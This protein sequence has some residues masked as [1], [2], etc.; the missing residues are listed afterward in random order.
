[1]TRGE[2]DY[3]EERRARRA[4]LGLPPPEEW[5]KLPQH[6]FLIVFNTASA[7]DS[8]ADIDDYFAFVEKEKARR[9]YEAVVNAAKKRQAHP[10]F[11][12]AEYSLREECLAINGVKYKGPSP[13]ESANE[14]AMRRAKIRREIKQ[15]KGQFA[16]AEKEKACIKY[17]ALVNAAKKRQAH[18]RFRRAEN[19]LREECLAIDGVKYKGPSPT[20]SANDTTVRRRKIRREIKLKKVKQK[21]QRL[22]EQQT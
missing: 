7:A 9:K 3:E 18:L 6:E 5:S 15:R 19:S 14:T 13:T 21:E 12:R 2:D 22:N 10:I 1:M 20:E 17:E 4:R 16:S 8:Q 11:R